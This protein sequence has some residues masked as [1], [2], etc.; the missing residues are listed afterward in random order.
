[1]PI[2]RFGRILIPCAALVL[3]ACSSFGPGRL[4]HDQL[5][6]SRALNDASK[7][8]T[9]ANIVGVRYADSPGFLSVSQVIAAYTFERSGNAIL[10]SAGA[11]SNASYAQLGGSAA[12]S[13]RPTFTFTP[14][15]G[16]AYA[17]SYIRPLSPSLVLPLAQGGVPID[18]LLRIAVQSI[19]RLQNSSALGGPHSEGS[20]GF[21]RLL[22]A[23]RRLQLAGV[24]NVR[25][26][27]TDNGGHVY[28]SLDPSMRRPNPQIESDT[29]DVR[30]MLGLSDR[31]TDYEIVYGHSTEPDVV[32]VTTRSVQGILA[33]LGAQI[34]VPAEDIERHDTMPT[35]GLVG[36][37]T[38]PTIVVHNGERPAPGAFADIVYRGRHFWIEQSDFDSKFALSV[39]QNLIALAAIT[40]NDKT[41]VVTIPAS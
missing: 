9:L 27:Q 14:V 12:F 36:G 6:Y 32:T 16:D 19:G 29:R 31:Q 15:T 33:T 39:V 13:N 38:R 22:A 11:G 23:L 24:A 34:E 41:P 18:L 7:R 3:G 4:N 21:F 20:P 10:N 37:E 2:A 30:Q 8:Q 40:Q 35:V 1:M 26:R 17:T 5:D 28:L 25:Y